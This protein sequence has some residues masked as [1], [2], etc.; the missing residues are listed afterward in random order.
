MI[1]FCLIK[2]LTSARNR[3]NTW[4]SIEARLEVSMLDLLHYNAV[5]WGVP[6]KADEIAV[7]GCQI[8]CKVYSGWIAL[9]T[10]FVEDYGGHIINKDD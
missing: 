2:D 8:F 5:S 10:R 6:A 1:R 7:A 4:R 3:S 9:A